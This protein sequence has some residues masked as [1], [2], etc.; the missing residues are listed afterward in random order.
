MRVER[1]Q[2]VLNY[3]SEVKLSTS[4]SSVIPFIALTPIPVLLYVT[5]PL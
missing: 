1:G 2:T 4:S 5:P 3:S